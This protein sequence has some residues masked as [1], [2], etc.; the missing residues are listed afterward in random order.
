M[1][2]KSYSVASN[3]RIIMNYEL[4]K[5]WKEAPRANFLRYYSGIVFEGPRDLIQYSP[6]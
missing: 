6:G 5:M 4:E 1:L 2:K 3:G